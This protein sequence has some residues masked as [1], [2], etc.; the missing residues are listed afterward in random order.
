MLQR[1]NNKW[2]A[3]V[4]LFR[5]LWIRLFVYKSIDLLLFFF[6]STWTVSPYPRLIQYIKIN[7]VFIILVTIFWTRFSFLLLFV[8]LSGL[9]VIHLIYREWFGCFFT[10][11]F[12]FIIIIIENQHVQSVLPN[13]FIS[14]AFILLRPNRKCKAKQSNYFRCKLRSA[15]W[16]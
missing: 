16:K 13:V 14:F 7:S 12:F 10:N 1:K 11:N 8:V 4:S 6:F 2:N 15:V 5:L 9:M 3:A